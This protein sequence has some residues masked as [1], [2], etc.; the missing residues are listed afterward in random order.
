VH[1]FGLISLCIYVRISLE[2]IPRNG[3]AGSN[4]MRYCQIAFKGSFTNLDSHQPN[5]T[6][7][8][9][10]P[11]QYSMVW[12]SCLFV[13]RCLTWYV[14]LLQLQTA[15]HKFTHCLIQLLG[16]FLMIY[17]GFLYCFLQLSMKTQACFHL[18][19]TEINQCFP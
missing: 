16:F 15:V 17:R 9:Q 3:S 6:S 7:F 5:I 1:I 8:S 18:D 2:Q 4:F 10:H 19:T 14:L 12:A 11:C 13:R